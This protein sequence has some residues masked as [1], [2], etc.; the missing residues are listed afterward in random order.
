MEARMRVQ[1]YTDGSCFP[2]PGPGGWGVVLKYGQR[3]KKLSGGVP[4]TTTNNRMELRAVIEALK[5]IKA[6]FPIDIYTDSQYVINGITTWVTSWKR[7]GWKR[8]KDKEIKNLD[9]WKALDALVSEKD[10]IFK[11]VRGHDGDPMN[12]L[13]DWLAVAAKKALLP[14]KITGPQLIDPHKNDN[15]LGDGITQ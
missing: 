14:D 13:A 1:A 7:N 12:E 6:G 11:W 15:L 2:N 8:K 5:A 9:L 10:V 3:E 4:E